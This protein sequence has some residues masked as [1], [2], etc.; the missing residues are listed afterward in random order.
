MISVRGGLC[1]YSAPE[2]KYS[3]A[4]VKHVRILGWDGLGGGGGFK[5]V[6]LTYAILK[7]LT[8]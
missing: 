6:I 5:R 4:T 3:Y 2:P 7:F 1:D 8:I